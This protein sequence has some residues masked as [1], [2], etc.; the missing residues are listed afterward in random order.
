M[1]EKC[2]YCGE[3]LQVRFGADIYVDRPELVSVAYW[4]CD[5]CDAHC[6]M[7][8]N[9]TVANRTLRSLRIAAHKAFDPIWEDE[10][11]TR[12]DAYYWLAYQLGIPKEECHIGSMRD[13]DCWQIIKLSEAKLHVLNHLQ[14]QG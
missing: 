14:A 13:A 8:S 7:S 1:I 5:S 12:T 3:P 9:S 10:Y 4:R 6:R 11:M 2:A